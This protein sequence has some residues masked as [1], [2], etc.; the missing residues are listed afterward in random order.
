MTVNQSELLN[1]FF[2]KNS[3][4]TVIVLTMQDQTTRELHWTSF[5]LPVWW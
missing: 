4:I 5:F 1:K 3:T 2:K